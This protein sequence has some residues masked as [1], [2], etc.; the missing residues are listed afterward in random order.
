MCDVSNGS[1][2]DSLESF[3]LLLAKETRR[4]L[5]RFERQ[6]RATK[7]EVPQLRA[8]VEQF[9]Y[10]EGV[11]SYGVDH[12]LHEKLEWD[13]RFV[14]MLVED[15][16]MHPAHSQSIQSISGRIDASADHV[17][18]LLDKFVRALVSKAVEE[19]I[20]DEV[21]LEH[22]LHFTRDIEV[23]PT[24]WKV[25]AWLDGVWLREDQSI[26]I[27]D[28]TMLRRPAPLDLEMEYTI[29]VPTVSSLFMGT[30]ARGMPSAVLEMQVIC[31][32]QNAAKQQVDQTVT[33]LRLFKLGSI[34]Y[35]L[36]RY[37]PKSV[38]RPTM[39]AYTSSV[40]DA[41]YKYGVSKDV[42]LALRDFVR[43]MKPLLP[44]DTWEAARSTDPLSIALS[45][46]IDALVK[47]SSV[48]SRITSAITCLE[49]LF[50]KPQ[51]RG[52]LSLRLSLRVA[53]LLRYF[54]FKPLEV[55]SKVSLAYNIRS[56]FVHG[57]ATKEKAKLSA[58]E[59]CGLLLEY[60]RVSLQIFYQLKHRLPKE[61]LID[62]LDHSLIDR[63]AYIDL[64][65]ELS[66]GI[67]AIR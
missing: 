32:D 66:E 26:Q 63:V 2:S 8:R 55:R 58:V 15:I 9:Q 43:V 11:R 38:L 64:K 17:G 47:P 36:V 29:N 65:E 40:V 60:S 62:K 10:E 50:L 21:I 45:R 52:E 67:L 59:L 57:S 46:Y 44:A 16:R 5:D 7:V 19:P 28:N 13:R 61:R 39:A 53:A 4:L 6:G 35:S 18:F 41:L 23:L 14:D 54:G 22:V 56:A 48:E 42:E 37:S 30:P 31:K 12:E 25:T 3:L 49:A 33:I 20:T 24:E 1:K 27:E 34:S 51:E